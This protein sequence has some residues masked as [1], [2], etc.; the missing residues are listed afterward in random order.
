[1][2]KRY[3]RGQK[4]KHLQEIAR[5]NGELDY[6]RYQAETQFQRAFQQ[7]IKNQG[8]YEEAMK[9]MSYNLSRS[10][11]DHSEKLLAIWNREEQFRPRFEVG[12]DPFLSKGVILRA[13]IPQLV[14]QKV[15]MEE[16]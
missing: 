14:Y 5:L 10:L 9:E 8:L 3:G 11:G 6:Q 2:S 1:M 4:R 13:T 15:V 7:F 16:P 12:N